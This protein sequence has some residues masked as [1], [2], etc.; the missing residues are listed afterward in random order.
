MS[1]FTRWLRLTGV[2]R[3]AR[4]APGCQ[5]SLLRGGVLLLSLG[6]SMAQWLEH[7]SRKPGVGSS[8]LPGGSQLVV[9]RVL[10]TPMWKLGGRSLREC[11]G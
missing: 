5:T 10:P 6:A 1:C 8:N 4:R 2:H 7:R 9:L 3:L 11:C